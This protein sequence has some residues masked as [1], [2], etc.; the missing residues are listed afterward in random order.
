MKTAFNVLLVLLGILAGWHLKPEKVI[1]KVKY[2]DR[3]I[4]KTDTVT[5]IK[6]VEKIVFRTQMVRDTVLVIK[7]VHLKRFDLIS[8][9]PLRRDK[10]RFV[11][12]YFNPRKQRYEQNIYDL[13]QYW[14]KEIYYGI[15]YAYSWQ[16]RGGLSFLLNAQLSYKKFVFSL[17]TALIPAWQDAQIIVGINRR[18]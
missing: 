18:W 4:V 6:P 2:Q 3:I 11:L 7:P 14:R 5:T 1:T 9:N 17:G 16:N 13:R 8:P 12:T 15:G 10:D